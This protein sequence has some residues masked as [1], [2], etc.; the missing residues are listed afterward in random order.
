MWCLAWAGI[1]MLAMSAGPAAHGAER[2]GASLPRRN[3]VVEVRTVLS[4]DAETS[5]G[6]GG[7]TDSENTPPAPDF[8]VGTAPAP[9]DRAPPMQMVQVLNGEWAQLRFARDLP[10]Q[11]LRAAS[12]QLGAASAAASAGGAGTAA[13]PATAAP[14]ATAGTPAT[15]ARGPNAGTS[16]LRG[17]AVVNEL[18]WLQAGQSLAVQARWPGGMQ[19]VTII[20]RYDVA[21]AEDSPGAALPT[22]RHQQA[23]T[24][25][26]VP[27]G[28]WT[29]FASI[30]AAAPARQEA[31]GYTVSTQPAPGRA[32]QALQLRV[33]LP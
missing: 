30:A 10:I 14:R 31:G 7:A 3:L 25:L 33:R 12:M 27:L 9:A 13:T 22:Q 23:G 6:A 1:G 16:G 15:P 21:A 28:R 26:A 11:W 20:I 17:G 32:G 5:D 29:T 19:P 4:Q 18:T 8:T 24:T 2:A